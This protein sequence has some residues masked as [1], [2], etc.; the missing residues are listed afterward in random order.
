MHDSPLSK[1]RRLSKRRIAPQG[2]RPRPRLPCETRRR[3]PYRRRVAAS[4]FEEPAMRFA[5]TLAARL[6]RRSAAASRRQRGG[7]RRQI[8]VE[9]LQRVTRTLSSDEFQGRAP[10]HRGRD[11]HDRVPLPGIPARRPAGPAIMAAGIQDVPLVEI[12]AQGSP[13]LH[14]TGGDGR[15]Q[16][17]LPHRLYRR[18]LPRPA[19]RLGRQQ[20]HRLRRL[21]HQ[22]ARARLE[23]LCRARRPRQDGHHPRQRS[24]LADARPRTARS[25]AGR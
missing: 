14:V 23:R 25:T 4:S 19:A 18:V 5:P 9:T 8:S 15:P 22:R 3:G 11:A 7:R 10:G 2:G 20:R 17:R 1:C 16:F 6:S 13:Q 24:R 12:T 21:R